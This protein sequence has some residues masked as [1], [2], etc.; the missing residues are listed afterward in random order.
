MIYFFTGAGMAADSGLATF[1]D[2]GGLW[3]S[4]D[5]NQVCNFPRFTRDQAIRDLTFQFYNERKLQYAQAKP[6]AGYKAIAKLQQNQPLKVITS[7]IDLLHEVAGTLDV[8]HLHGRIDRMSCGDCFHYWDIAEQAFEPIECPICSSTMVKPGIV[9]F[10]EMAPEYEAL[11]W[12]INGLT[13]NDSFVIV[14]TSLKVVD[15]IAMIKAAGRHPQI[16]YI[17]KHIPDSLRNSGVICIENS[18]EQG[19]LQWIA[20]IDAAK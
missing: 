1:R 18:A 11:H 6:H 20:N 9:F 17:D 5:I 15:P 8:L 2:S 16:I 10:G 4:Y 7:N 3:E 14:G 13:S 12:L 19:L